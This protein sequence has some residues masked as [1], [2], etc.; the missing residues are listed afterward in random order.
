MLG[1]MMTVLPPK[2]KDTISAQ[3]HNIPLTGL[4]LQITKEILVLYRA[5]FIRIAEDII[6]PKAQ[7]QSPSEIP[8]K[9]ASE[10]E[11]GSDAF[12]VSPS[13]PPKPLP[14]VDVPEEALAIADEVSSH[15]SEGKGSKPDFEPK[16]SVFSTRK[17]IEETLDWE[18][19]RD[20]V[21]DKIG[22]VYQKKSLEAL[23]SMALEQFDA[24]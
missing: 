20:Y 16:P 23:R 9:I 12:G 8:G 10:T 14:Q 18:G 6:N 11:G 13:D 4:K 3:G 2:G 17:E 22:Y 5:G 1:K 21:A 7:I 19:L 15:D 24:N